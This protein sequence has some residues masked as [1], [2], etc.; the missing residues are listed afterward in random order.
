M[1]HNQVA[2]LPAKHA[3]FEVKEAPIWTPKAHE[4]LIRNVSVAVNPVDWKSM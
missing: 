3:P 1:A 2:W 4:I